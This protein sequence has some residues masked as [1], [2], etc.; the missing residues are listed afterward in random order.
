MFLGDPRMSLFERV[1]KVR[2]GSSFRDPPAE[3]PWH[4]WPCFPWLAL[5][6]TLCWPEALSFAEQVLQSRTFWPTLCAVRENLSSCEHWLSFI[7][8]ELKEL[9]LISFT[10]FLISWP[11]LFE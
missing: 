11:V 1:L 7:Y 8:W 9:F 2:T 6:S 10:N 4:T 3:S 5:F